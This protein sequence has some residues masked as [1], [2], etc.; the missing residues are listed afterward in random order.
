[1][2]KI[3]LFFLTLIGFL[4]ITQKEA[5]A[6][7]ACNFTFEPSPLK[8][9]D[10]GFYHTGKLTITAVDPNDPNGPLDDHQYY[11]LLLDPDGAGPCA[12]DP[13]DT[14]NQGCRT[15]RRQ[16][17]DGKIEAE[18]EV[19]LR[20]LFMLKAEDYTIRLC[21]ESDP[22]ACQGAPTCNPIDIKIGTKDDTP[23]PDDGP[24]DPAGSD[25]KITN[26]DDV[27]ACSQ[28]NVHFQVNCKSG[29][30]CKTTDLGGGADGGC[31][32]GRCRPCPDPVEDC[33]KDSDD[34]PIITN[35]PLSSPCDN[36]G[37][38]GCSHIKTV[39]GFVST[40]ADDFTRWLL[41]FVLSI[42][43]GIVILI[44]IISGYRLMTSAGD[45]EKIK[46]ARDQLTAAIVGLLFIIFS[47]VILE[48][49]TRDILGL[50][51]FGSP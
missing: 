11:G 35:S 42:S 10:D 4:F 6:Q 37:D 23:P 49:I 31:S 48:L 8:V 16:A 30:Y 29:L 44:I 51:G 46:N 1:M 13:T 5:L 25:C 22:E 45:P 36:P 38:S 41:G 24:G 17:N 32:Q 26:E 43:G 12:A 50:P 3:L 40:S 21:N 7:V 20:E 2:R 39:F 33:Y 27:N 15:D 34:H 19:Q 47:L 9:G 18:G 14:A 28:R